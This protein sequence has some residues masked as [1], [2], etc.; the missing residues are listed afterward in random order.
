MGYFEERQTFNQWWLICLVIFAQAGLVYGLYQETAGFSQF[1]EPIKVLFG[2]FFIILFLSIFTL[3]LHTR[4]SSAGI[5][6]E[7]HPIP[8][9]TRKFHWKEI[10][11]IYVRKYSAIGEYGGWGV[12]GM[13]PAKAYT[14]SGQYGIQIVTKDGRKFLIGTQKSEKVKPI[15]NKLNTIHTKR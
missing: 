6:A 15:L 2:I 4:I 14:V 8:F 5:V 3:R 13:F 10:D 9:F 11:E 7:L 1:D 12:R